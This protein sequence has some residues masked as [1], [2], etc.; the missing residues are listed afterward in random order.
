MPKRAGYVAELRALPID[1]I[2][3]YLGRHSNLPGPRANLTLLDAAGDVLPSP[4]AYRFAEAEDE[5]LACCGAVALGRVALDDPA[6]ESALARL[7]NLAAD[8]RWRVREAVAIALQRIGDQDPARLRS[9]VADWVRSKDALVI[10]AALAGICEPRLLADQLTVEQAVAACGVATEFVADA[11]ADQRKAPAMR[12][13]RQALGYCW[14]VAVAADVQR[15][16]PAFLALDV[17]DPDVAWI[18]AENRKK[19]R[20]KRILDAAAPLA[21]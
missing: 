10:R 1:Q 18:V 9:I 17:D 15:G 21:R 5:Y 20:L 7:L 19:Q 8:D 4:V 13:L 14:S 11:P 12:T 3:D 2:A 16:L 6:D